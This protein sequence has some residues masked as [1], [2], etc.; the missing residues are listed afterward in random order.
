M[1]P[2]PQLTVE[3]ASMLSDVKP[4]EPIITAFEP[5]MYTLARAKSV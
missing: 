1:G 2:P 4:T 3:V 5:E